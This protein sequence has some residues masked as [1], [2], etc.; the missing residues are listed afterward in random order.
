MKDIVISGQ[1]IFQESLIFFSCVLAAIAVNVYSIIHSET[2]W[3]ELF[4][5]LHIT[6]AEAVLFFVLVATVRGLVHCGR[7]VFRE[8]A[9]L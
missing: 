4:T 1:C 2:K 8:K 6:F 5:M 3:K 9:D 7:K